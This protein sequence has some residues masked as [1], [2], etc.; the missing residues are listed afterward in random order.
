MASLLR[1][2]PAQ[3]HTH[4]CQPETKLVTEGSQKA[5]LSFSVTPSPLPSTP[6]PHTLPLRAY[7]LTEHPRFLYHFY[8]PRGEIHIGNRGDRSRKIPGSPPLLRSEIKQRSVRKDE[9]LKK[10]RV[11]ALR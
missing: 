4:G 2:D 9:S 6:I 8:K 7:T 1:V 5:A 3:H 10:K 11:A